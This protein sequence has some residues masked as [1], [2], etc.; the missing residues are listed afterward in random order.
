MVNLVSILVKLPVMCGYYN[1]LMF[2]SIRIN[3]SLKDQ[4]DERPAPIGGA[5]VVLMIFRRTVT[6]LV[7]LCICKAP[8]RVRYS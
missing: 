2:I 3:T 6:T 8:C 4:S 5:L 1:T 7:R